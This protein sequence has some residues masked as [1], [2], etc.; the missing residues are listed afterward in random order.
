MTLVS[1]S[2]DRDLDAVLQ[3]GLDL[4]ERHVHT[5][6]NIEGVDAVDA[7]SKA[8]DSADGD[9]LKS[10]GRVRVTF[11][12]EFFHVADEMARVVDVVPGVEVHAQW[13]LLAELSQ[14]G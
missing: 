2:I 12:P 14:I 11:R 1:L 7:E 8:L 13:H 6:A 3:V 5:K 9:T 10:A 4:L